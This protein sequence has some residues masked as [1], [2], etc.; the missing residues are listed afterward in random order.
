MIGLRSQRGGGWFNG[1][2][3]NIGS[4]FLIDRSPSRVAQGFFSGLASSGV[5]ASGIHIRMPHRHQA[6]SS[7]KAVST[8]PNGSRHAAT[9]AVQTFIGFVSV[10]TPGLHVLAP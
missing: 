4:T 9:A 8:L 10:S 3:G 2:N 1:T 5:K 7:S 6:A